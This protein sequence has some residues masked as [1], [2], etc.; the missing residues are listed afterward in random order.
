VLYV[1]SLPAARVGLWCTSSGLCVL[2]HPGV[3]A[4]LAGRYMEGPQHAA[5]CQLSASLPYTVQG[6]L[7]GLSCMLV[8]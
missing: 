2:M 7:C 1:Y 5:P 6:E 4:W 3:Y 8:G